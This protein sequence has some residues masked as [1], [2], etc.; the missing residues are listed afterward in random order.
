MEGVGKM[1]KGRRET[2]DRGQRRHGRWAEEDG[3]MEDGGR[4][5]RADSAACK[6]FLSGCGT[7][8]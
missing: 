4:G 1:G 5:E 3:G 7:I 8:H 2:R 6:V